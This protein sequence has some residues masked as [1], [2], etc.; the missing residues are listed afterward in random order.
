M[1]TRALSLLIWGGLLLFAVPVSAQCMLPTLWTSS[2]DSNIVRQMPVGDLSAVVDFEIDLGPTNPV[3]GVPGIAYDAVSDQMYL[4]IQQADPPGAPPFLATWDPTDGTIGIIGSV[5]V[6]FDCLDFNVDGEVHTLSKGTASPPQAF[7][8]LSLLSGTPSDL[9]AITNPEDGQTI[10][11]HPPS[12]L[13][14]QAAGDS[15]A[16]FREVTATTAPGTPCTTTSITLDAGVASQSVSAI[17]WSETQGAFL[18]ATGGADG[19]LYTVSTTGAST[20]IGVLD[21]DATD[22]TL[23]MEM[24]P[25]PG[26]DFRRG[27]ANGDGGVDISDAVFILGELFIPMSPTG[28]CQDADDVNDDGGVDISDAVFLLATLFIPMSPVPPAPGVSICGPD[29]TM[30]SVECLFYPSCL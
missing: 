12:G 11:Y 14:Y 15:V 5:V 28:P 21:F 2:R 7:C 27:D 24:G 16:S 13:F 6:A 8:E 22:M 18:W 25:C 17:C 23:T 4:L 29:P 30:D 26:T 3:V 19:D 1:R 10:A 9:C 20:F